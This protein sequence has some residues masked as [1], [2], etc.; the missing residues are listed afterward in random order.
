M[1]VFEPVE[2]TIFGG[3]SERIIKEKTNKEVQARSIIE[4]IQSHEAPEEIISVERGIRT[5]G[6]PPTYNYILKLEKIVGG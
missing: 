4:A 2:K 5:Q 1:S 6:T 3:K